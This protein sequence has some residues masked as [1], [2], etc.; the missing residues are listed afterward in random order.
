MTL[1][2]DWSEFFECVR[3][4]AVDFVIVGGHALAFHGVPRFTRD[5]D[6]FVRA[7]PDNAAKIVAALTAFGF[8]GAESVLQTL[9]QPGGMVQIGREPYRI[10]LLTEVSGLDYATA[11]SHAVGGYLGEQPVRFLSLDDLRINKRAAGRPRDL[12]DLSELGE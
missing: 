5:I 2:R 1:P 3:A 9:S 12:V 7:D 10:D 11:A 8:V 4:H 6:L